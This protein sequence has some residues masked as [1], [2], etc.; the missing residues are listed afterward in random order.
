MA[1]KKVNCVNFI[2][3]K[4]IIMKLESIDFDVECV[5]TMWVIIWFGHIKH[6]TSL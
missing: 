4:D 5:D 3:L 6:V 1:S 2:H